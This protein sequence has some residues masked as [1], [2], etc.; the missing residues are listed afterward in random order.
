[1]RIAKSRRMVMSTKSVY[2]CGQITGARFLDAKFG[3]R[4]IVY[5]ALT[6]YGITCFSP[7]RHLNIDEVSEDDTASM[8]PMG[9]ETGVLSTPRGLTERDRFDTFRSDIVFCNLVDIEKISVGSMI[10]LGWADAKRIPV[11]LCME[12]GNL[13][14]HAMVQALASWIVPT[15]EEGIQV[16]LDLFNPGL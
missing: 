14:E 15:L 9:A 2:L 12:P 1:M 13:H 8:S 5:E 11:L 3:W 6:P 4:E 16:A 7:L 10:E